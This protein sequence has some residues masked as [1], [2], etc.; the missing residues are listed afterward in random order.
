MPFDPSKVN[1][2]VRGEVDL[3]FDGPDAAVIRYKVDG[4]SGAKA[5][6]RQIF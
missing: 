4:Q 1:V 6:I 2:V 5:I 3:T